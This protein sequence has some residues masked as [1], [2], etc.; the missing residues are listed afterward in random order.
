MNK[1]LKLSCTKGLP[2]RVVRSYKARCA[3]L[4][5]LCLCLGSRSRPALCIWLHLAR[6]L[7]R[8]GCL[9]SPAPP[10]TLSSP[11]PPC[12]LQEKRSAYAPTEDT[13]VRYD[14]IYRIVKCWRT[15]G[16]QVSSACGTGSRSWAGTHGWMSVIQAAAA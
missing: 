15:K 8:H 2:V 12:Q 9:G 10:S 4:R 16:K 13:P 6:D 1:A 5:T 7:R 3:A 14:G 11:C